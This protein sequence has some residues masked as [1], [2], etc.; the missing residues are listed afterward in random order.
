M[1]DTGYSWVCPEDDPGWDHKYCII[2]FI[3]ATKLIGSY[4]QLIVI[5]FFDLETVFF[6]PH[7][8]LQ[9]PANKQEPEP[10]MVMTTEKSLWGAD[11]TATKKYSGAI[12][13]LHDTLHFLDMLI[14]VIQP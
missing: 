12:S 6:L 13:T 8:K 9:N 14:Q 4:A 5:H 7:V 2:I 1:Q 10:V 3:E 11:T